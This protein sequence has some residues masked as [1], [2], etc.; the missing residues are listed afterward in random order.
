MF[1]VALAASCSALA[2][3]AAPTGA[4]AKTRWVVAD[5]YCP[6]GCAALVSDFIKAQVGTAV[7]LSN[8]Q[9]SAPFL[10]PCSG[11]V[12]FQYATLETRQLAS[13]L[14]QG[15]SGKKQFTAENMRLASPRVLTALALCNSDGSDST[16]ARILSIEPD[17]IRVL[18]EGWSIIEL[19]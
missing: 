7:T 14:S 5:G 10:D 16:M 11:T 3:N 6:V 13:E 9:F 1:T 17:R 19:R 18:F 12:H 4:F 2:Q 15:L 8:N